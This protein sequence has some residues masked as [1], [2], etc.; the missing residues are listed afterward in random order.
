ME[1]SDF[2]DLNRRVVL[3]AAAAWAPPFAR[4]FVGRV[5]A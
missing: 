1:T 4:C 2:E 5:R 3:V